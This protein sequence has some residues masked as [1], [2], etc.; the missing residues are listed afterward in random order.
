MQLYPFFNGAFALVKFDNK[1][2]FKQKDKVCVNILHIS[3]QQVK[4]RL[5]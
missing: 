2:C 3:N 1:F 4:S 5:L